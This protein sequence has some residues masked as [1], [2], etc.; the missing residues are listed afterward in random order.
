MNYIQKWLFLGVFFFLLM[1]CQK[2]DI[3]PA[4]TATTPL[5]VI[6]F[7]DSQD[8]TGLKAVQDLVVQA[9]GMEEIYFGPETTNSISIPLRT[10]QNFTDYT[11]TYNSDGEDENED[12]VTFRY[13]PNPEYINRACGFRINY[14]NIDVS[15]QGEDNNWILST[16]ILQQNIENE[17]EA[18]ISFTH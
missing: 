11:F 5:L 13:S 7:Y 9:S 1:G 3:C 12:I 15:V 8:P 17:T 18:H 14:S 16:L 4:G 2:D 10:D 6:E